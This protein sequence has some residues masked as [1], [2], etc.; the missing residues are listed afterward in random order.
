MYR[1]L[2]VPLDGSALAERAL[3]HAEALARLFDSELILLRVVVSPYTLVAPD[4]ILAGADPDLPALRAHAEAY[5]RSV[6][7]RLENQG[8]RVRTVV[9]DGPVAEMILDQAQAQEADLIVMS[10]HGR[11][12]VRRWVYG[13]VAERVLQGAACPVLLIRAAEA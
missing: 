11:G 8:M 2:L 7:G 4:L 5:L 3:G 12:G 13:S 10:T 6:A 1:R 9:C